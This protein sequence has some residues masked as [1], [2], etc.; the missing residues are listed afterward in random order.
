MN[1]EIKKIVSLKA[2]LVSDTITHSGIIENLSRDSLYLRAVKINPASDFTPGEFLE[3]HLQ[4]NSGE[5]ISL[6]GKIMWSYDTPPH[7]L[8]KSIGIKI[9]EENPDYEELFRNI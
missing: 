2:S 4:S 6:P 8:T 9:S 3:I 5:D 1:L 7:G